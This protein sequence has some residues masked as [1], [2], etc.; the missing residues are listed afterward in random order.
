MNCRRQALL[1]CLDSSVT[2]LT[3]ECRSSGLPVK[4]WCQQAQIT[5]STY[6]QR[7]RNV[8][9]S[10]ETARKRMLK[11]L[12]IILPNVTQTAVDGA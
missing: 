2:E 9:A 1:L 3:K 4:M 7:A 6:Y 5:P 8:L 10:A 12:L 11:H